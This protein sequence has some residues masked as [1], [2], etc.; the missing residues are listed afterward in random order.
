MSGKNSDALRQRW[1]DQAYRERQTEVNRAAS[2]L[3]RVLSKRKKAMTNAESALA[4]WRQRAIESERLL[5]TYRAGAAVRDARIAE[6]EAERGAILVQVQAILSYEEETN[7]QPYS[8]VAQML[9]AV[10]GLPQKE[11][12]SIVETMAALREAAGGAFDGIDPVAFVK[13]VRG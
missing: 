5:D 7:M 9:R 12:P 8:S 13:D 4:G 1:R 3:P 2:K 6:L 10:L 11:P